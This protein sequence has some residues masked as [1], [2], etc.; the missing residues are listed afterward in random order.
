[1][2]SGTLSTVSHVSVSE[3]TSAF[4][5]AEFRPE[6][7]ASWAPKPQLQYPRLTKPVTGWTDP[8][9]DPTASPLVGPNS[10][11]TFALLLFL[12][13]EDQLIQTP[14]LSPA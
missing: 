10:V 6:V 14:L 12:S 3:R 7:Q 9:R 5:P 1:M 2:V 4:R 13:L 8:R 11:S